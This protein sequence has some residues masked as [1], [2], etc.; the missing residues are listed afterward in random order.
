VS[1]DLVR[2]AS[3]DGQW[4]ANLRCYDGEDGMT[5]V[6]AE[7]KPAGSDVPVSRGPYKFATAH[8]AFRFMQEAVL[9]LQYL[10]CSV[11]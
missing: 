8:E 7:I 2:E 3:V 11:G 10:G 9:A 5:I 4:V 1:G 6:E